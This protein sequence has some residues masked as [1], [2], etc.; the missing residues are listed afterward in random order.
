MKKGGGKKD[1]F[2]VGFS[3][4][5]H[6]RLTDTDKIRLI[7][8]PDSYLQSSQKEYRGINRYMKKMREKKKKMQQN[9]SRNIHF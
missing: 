3:D 2:A 4:F 7:D 9:C 5:C 6:V 8:L 1:L